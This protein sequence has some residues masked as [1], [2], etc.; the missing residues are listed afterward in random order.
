MKWLPANVPVSI[1]PDELPTATLV[2]LDLEYSEDTNE[3][4]LVGIFDGNTYYGYT[5]PTTQLVAYLQNVNW[6]CQ[7]GI[8][9]E[10]PILN[11][12]YGG[13]R[14]E[15]IVAD[16]KIM[17]YVFDSTRN[18]YA[19]KP[20]VKE[21]LGAEYPTYEE[22]KAQYGFKNIGELDRNILID[23][24]GADCYYTWKLWEYFRKHY[25]QSQ[26]NF[27]NTIEQPTNYLI[28][29]MEALG[30]QVDVEEAKR[31]HEKFF[32]RRNGWEIAFR[33]HLLKRL[34]L[35]T[36]HKELFKIKE[37][38]AK[39]KGKALT[40]KQIG[41][42]NKQV[43]SDLN[44]NSPQQILAALLGIGLK[45]KNTEEDTI[46]KYMKD[47]VVKALLEYR[48]NEKICSTYTSVLIE[49]AEKAPD[50]RIHGNFGQNTQTGRLSSNGPNLQ[51][52]PAE[53]RSCYVAKEG[54]SFIEA[55]WSNLE[56]RIPGHFSGDPGIIEELSKR[57]GDIHRKTARLMF[58][59]QPTE[60]QRKIAKTCN[61]LLTNSGRAKRLAGELGCSYR[62]AEDTYNRF[63]QGYK[64]LGQWTKETKEQA[65]RDMGI[66]TLFGR[67]VR[68]PGL[69]LWC[70][71][72]N[73]PV[74][75]K[76]YFCK[77]CFKREETEREA[78]SVRVQGSGADLIKLAMLR[79]YKEYQYVPV[80]TVHDSLMYEVEDEKIEEVAENV[81]Y[82]MEN[83]VT[84][85]VPLY[86]D[87]GV[88]KNWGEC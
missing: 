73:C 1:N 87:I 37:Q 57:D 77:E 83:I 44:L 46:K 88:G 80:L 86:V 12:L 25:T 36:W 41:N 3:L 19:L 79:L 29:R 55:D 50:R 24:N 8:H 78:V 23:Y 62:E 27:L 59:E 18:N 82:V 28:A 63:W 64:V 68:L 53:V 6:I 65:K 70:G 10:L 51:N 16:T 81:Q 13:F 31:L 60:A 9:A 56:W 47:K 15:Q 58:G 66:S 72:A 30:V 85:K 26:W 76:D 45:V 71:R 33:A 5:T 52:Q 40:A 39:K 61:F 7:D 69:S 4:V 11:K 74:V 20:M 34:N 54:H 35:D 32:K 14:P 17:G 42:V 2:S 38:V 75:A 84:L 49:K 48:G 67:K 21:C 43:L 22:L